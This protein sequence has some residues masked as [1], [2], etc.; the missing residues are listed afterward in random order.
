VVS[1]DEIAVG[2]SLYGR[3]MGRALLP[4]FVTFLDRDFRRTGRLDLPAAP[5]QMRALDFDPG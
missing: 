3:R 4:G 1:E 2:S 5:T